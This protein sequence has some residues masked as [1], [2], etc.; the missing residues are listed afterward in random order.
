MPQHRQHQHEDLVRRDRRHPPSLEGA[1]PTKLVITNGHGGNY[2]L[3]NIVQEANVDGPAVSLLPLGS[4]WDRAREH[5]GLV[6]E[7]H[8]D[9]HA[10]EIETS[11]L[12]HVAP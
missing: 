2:V 1:G 10:S 5:A 4:D 8:A 12:L 7:R 6:S 9:M 3:S 11:L